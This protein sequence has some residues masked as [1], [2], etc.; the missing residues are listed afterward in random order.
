MAGPGRIMQDLR[1][2]R[3]LVVHPRDEDG[4]ALVA[5]LKRLGCEV[6]ATWPL[7]PVL[8]A[9]VDTVFL[10][11]ED[12]QVANALHLADQHQPAIIAIVTYESPTSLQAIIDLNAH[13]VISK[14]LRPLGILTQFALARYRHSYEKRLAG[15][16]QKL[17]DTLKGRRLVER[18][19]SA[20]RTING[21]DEESA[22]KL[23]RDQATAKR[24]PM[25][26][27]AESIIAAHETMK[28]LGLQTAGRN[29]T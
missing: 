20:L 17:E 11:I 28:S 21:L 9:D 23:L 26:A 4:D 29:D 18:A 2:A 27:I 1:R 6:R 25:A 5:H 8:P 22:Y 16:V 13:G 12:V 3:V 14:P 19:V 10:H 24:M 15:K 7:P